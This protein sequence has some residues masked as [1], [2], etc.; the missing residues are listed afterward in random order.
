M[1]GGL[2][3]PYHVSQGM[4]VSWRFVKIK[5]IVNHEGYYHI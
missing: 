4:T 1:N 3:S 2:K 5:K